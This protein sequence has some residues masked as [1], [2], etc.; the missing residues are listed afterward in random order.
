M[1]P[2]H[3]E[4][5]Q[6]DAS[7][8][9]GAL[10]PGDRRAYEAHLEECERCRVAVAELASMPGLLT[11][12]R[13]EV[14]TWDGQEE[15]V[16][17]PANLVDLVTERR[18]RRARSIRNRVI[19]A[20]SGLAAVVALAIAVPAFLTTDAVPAPVEVVALAPVGDTTMTVSLGLTPVAW[21]TRIAITCDYPAGETWSGV[22]GPWSYS[23][24]LTDV[25]GKISQV[26]SWKAVAGK[27]IQLEAATAI[28]LDRI[29]SVR[30]LSSDGAA[31]LS[32]TVRSGTVLS[33]TV[34]G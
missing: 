11:R 10:T 4:F 22:Y 5:A 12:A 17:P 34:R 29:A 8:V 7:Y 3:T 13:P 24:E 15:L 26:S 28:P 9:L 16:G 27:T 19:L 23:L 18:A 31:V 33:D 25:A 6:W 21:G 30:V 2:D 14:E 32:G 20:A 1:N